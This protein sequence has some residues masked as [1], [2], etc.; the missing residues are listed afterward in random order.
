MSKPYNVNL[1]YSIGRTQFTMPIDLS[2]EGYADVHYIANGTSFRIK[3]EER[4]TPPD[5][6]MKV[7]AKGTHGFPK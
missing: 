3:I 6:V 5:D 2:P 4:I 1:V 7:I